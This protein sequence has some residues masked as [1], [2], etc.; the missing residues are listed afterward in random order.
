MSVRPMARKDI[1]YTGSVLALQ[2]DQEDQDG[3]ENSKSQ[4]NLLTTEVINVVLAG[5][6]NC[7]N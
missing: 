2:D 6:N 1:F 7:K 4:V 5:F 3:R